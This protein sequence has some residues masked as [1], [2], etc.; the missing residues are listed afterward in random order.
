MSQFKNRLGLIL[1]LTDSGR[2]P[3]NACEAQFL[4]NEF[5]YESILSFRFVSN[6]YNNEAYEFMLSLVFN[7]MKNNNSNAL[8][9]SNGDNELCFFTKD[10]VYLENSSHI[11]DKGCFAEILKELKY[12]IF[13]GNYIF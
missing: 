4:K 12:C 8:F 11:W 5:A 9:L 2:Y 10:C 1:H 6:L 13:D 3:Y 7:L